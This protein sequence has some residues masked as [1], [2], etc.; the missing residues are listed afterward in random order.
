MYV[1]RE[2]IL[3]RRNIYSR[4]KRKQLPDTFLPRFRWKFGRENRGLERDNFYR[5]CTPH[6]VP[7]SKKKEVMFHARCPTS[8]IMRALNF[9]SVFGIIL[10]PNSMYVCA[11]SLR[12]LVQCVRVGVCE[13]LSAWTYVCTRTSAEPT[14][15]TP[16]CFL[17][18]NLKWGE[19]L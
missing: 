1:H 11:L 14:K 5:G 12:R 16:P 15:E 10:L 8:L 6:Q 9:I 19:N 7:G 4:H 18:V 3:C 13:A 2:K 17:P